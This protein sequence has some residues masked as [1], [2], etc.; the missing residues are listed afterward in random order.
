MSEE[1]QNAAIVVPRT[2][3]WGITLS[4]ALGLAMFLA[5][6][7]CLGDPEALS[8]TNYI[9]PF[10]QVLQN[11]TRSSAGTAVI[12]AVILVID[13]GLNIG[14]V[15][16][17]SR[18]LWSFARDRGVPGWRWISKVSLIRSEPMERTD[19]F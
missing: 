19:I 7:F 13:L 2:I 15:A 4:G 8:D 1:I 5:V 17:S 3:I 6:L 12:M 9:Y 14:V 16:A 11:A 18:M 10:I